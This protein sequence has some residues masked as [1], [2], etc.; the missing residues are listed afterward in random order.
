MGSGHDEIHTRTRDP[1]VSGVSLAIFLDHRQIAV[2]GA[3]GQFEIHRG[4]ACRDAQIRIRGDIGYASALVGE[5]VN[6]TRSCA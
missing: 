3:F 4:M 2:L 6:A 1:V 5:T